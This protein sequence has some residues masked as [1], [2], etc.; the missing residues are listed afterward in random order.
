MKQANNVEESILVSACLLG[1][2][3]RY[4]GK[5][6]YN[7]H[8]AAMVRNKHIIFACPEQLGGLTTPRPRNKI[9]GDRVINENDLDVTGC[10]NRGA[11]EFVKIAKK[12]KVKKLIL[13]SR[14]PS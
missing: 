11:K 14:S 6:A 3:C 4:D 5:N 8:V 1:I 7:K 12:F 9:V 13:K 2:N 10:F